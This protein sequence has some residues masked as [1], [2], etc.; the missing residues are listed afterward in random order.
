M[1]ETYLIKNDKTRLN[2]TLSTHNREVD[3]SS[4]SIATIIESIKDIN[5]QGAS[6][7]KHLFL[8]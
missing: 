1:S 7:L 3:G 6:F 5:K 8:C 2:D 4:P